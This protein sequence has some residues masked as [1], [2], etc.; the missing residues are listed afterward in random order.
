MAE[1]AIGP[2]QWEQLKPSQKKDFT[3]ALRKLVE[4]RYYPRWHKLFSNGTLSYGS[5]NTHAG[6]IVLNTVL[7]INQKAQAIAWR[8]DNKSNPARIVSLQV[9]QK[10]LLDTLHNRIN[11]RLK[12]AGFTALLSWLQNRAAEEAQH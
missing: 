2:S 10:D 1:K 9:D 12:K 4:Q 11:P 8:L 3:L 6:G 5:E 7:K